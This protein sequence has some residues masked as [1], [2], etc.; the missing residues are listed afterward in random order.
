MKT[1]RQQA[2]ER[3]VV[4]LADV[5]KQLDA[6]TLTVRTMTAKERAAHPPQPRPESGPGRKRRF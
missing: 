5:Q 2:E 4:K 1:L 6:G 3:R